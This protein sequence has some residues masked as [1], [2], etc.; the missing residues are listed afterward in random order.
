MFTSLPVLG[1][2]FNNLI[3]GRF[4][5][6]EPFL[7][8]YINENCDISGLM[9]IEGVI[10]SSTH[11]NGTPPCPK[12]SDV[13]DISHVL[14]NVINFVWER[15]IKGGFTKLSLINDMVKIN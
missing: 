10:C 4:S 12:L 11:L 6:S 3:A 1:T 5:E 14:R 9:Q 15:D 7:N 8:T 13:L 2:T